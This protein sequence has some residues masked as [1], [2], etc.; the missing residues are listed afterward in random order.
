MV[1]IFVTATERKLV[2][3]FPKPQAREKKVSNVDL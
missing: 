1:R 2:Q 3:R